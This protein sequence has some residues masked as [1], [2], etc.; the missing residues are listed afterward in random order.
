MNYARPSHKLFF[1]VATAVF[2]LWAAEKE[3]FLY[4]S[5]LRGKNAVCLFGILPRGV[6]TQIKKLYSPP[7]GGDTNKMRDRRAPGTVKR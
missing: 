4:S 7:K 2:L 3:D 5:P 1:H 6:R